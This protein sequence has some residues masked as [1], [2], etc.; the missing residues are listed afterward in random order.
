MPAFVQFFVKLSLAVAAG[1]TMFVIFFSTAGGVISGF[2]A[3]VNHEKVN[4]AVTAE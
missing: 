3:F 4:V 1:A 2:A